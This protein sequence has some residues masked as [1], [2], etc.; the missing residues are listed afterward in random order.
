M[1]NGFLLYL[2]LQDN[3]RKYDYMGKVCKAKPRIICFISKENKIIQNF[4]H[5]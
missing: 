3:E 1:P 5:I 2:F 4:F